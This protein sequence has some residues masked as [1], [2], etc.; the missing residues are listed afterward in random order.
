MN[1]RRIANR[2]LD[3]LLPPQCP[4]CNGVVDAHGVLC[5][6]CWQ[7]IDFLGDPRCSA[8]GL[9]FEFDIDPTEAVLCGACVR[10]HPPFTRARAVMVYGNV[11]RKLVLAF[12]HGD[13]TDTAPALGRWLARAGRALIEDAD[14]IAPVPLHWTRLFARRYN[15]AALLAGVVGEV[16]AVAVVQ[17]MLVRRKRTPP[18]GRMGWAKRRR[19]VAGAFKV[20]PARR[21]ALL[22]KRVLLIDDVLTTGATVAGCAKVLL[23]GGAAAVDVL[24]LARV[25]RAAV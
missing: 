5:G 22:G 25:V 11:S 18:Q 21:D 4:L 20:N 8:C 12:K 3:V 17:D 15:Q 2:A 10:E 16:S 24:T 6:G 14:V 19:N 9:P 7:Q 23:R 13:R 1:L